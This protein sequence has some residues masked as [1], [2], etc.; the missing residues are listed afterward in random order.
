MSTSRLFA[1]H[2][3]RFA[4]LV[5]VGLILFWV[6][7][8]SA[9]AQDSEFEIDY[10]SFT[11]SNGLR[12]IVHEDRKAPIVAVNMWYGV[13]SKDE[14]EGQT[15]FAHLFEHLMYNGS[16][17]YDGE[18][19]K[20]LEQVGATSV[21]GNTWFDRTV[22][23]ESVPTPALELILWMES[24]RMGHLLGAVTQEKL[25][26]QRGVVQN[27]KR[28][29]DNQP[30]GM[31]SYRLLEG[32]FPTGHPY[33][34]TTIGSMD[35]L[36]AA[37]LDDIHTW[38]K[39]YYGSANAV[40]VL[41][42]DIDEETARPLV[43]K[44]FGH[45]PSGPPLQVW[46]SN[47]PDRVADTSEILYDDVAQARH[48]K[49]WAVPGR[50]EQERAHLDLAA[51]VLGDGKPS[52]LYKALVHEEQIATTASAYVSAHQLASFFIS[53]VDVK[54]GVSPDTVSARRD[55]IIQDFLR[56]GPT[57]KEL[58]RVKANM[59]A[60]ILRGLES[61]SG[62]EGVAGILGQ[63][64]LYANDP[65]FLSTYMKWI[66]EASTDMVRDAARAWLSD[67]SHQVSVL[68]FP[69][70]SVLASAADRSKLPYPDTTPDLTFPEVQTAELSNGMTVH[71]AQRQ[72]TG[73]VNMA[74]SF[75]AGYAADQGRTLGRAS[76][77][78]AMMDEGAD[79]K[80]AFEI[81][82][83]LE[84]LG[85]QLQTYSTLD[86]SIVSFSG[87][88]EN[89]QPTLNLVSAIV[90][91]PDFDQAELDLFRERWI[92]G[93]DQEKS[94]PTQVALRLLPPMLYGDGHAYGV[95]FTGSGT[96]AS[97]QSLTRDDLV[98]FHGTWLQPTNA[99]L[100]IVGDIDMATL[101]PM[102]DQ[103]FGKWRSTKPVPIK[104]VSQVARSTGTRIVLIN[105]PGAPQ[106]VIIGGNLA[107]SSTAPNAIA[108]T[109]INDVLGGEFTARIN[110]NLREDK[111]W[112]YGAQSFFYAARGQRPFAVYAPVQTD[113]TAESISEMRRELTEILST[114]PPTTDELDSVVALSTK[115]LPGSYETGANV[116]SS[117]LS[118][119]RF[120]RSF[121]YPATLKAS[122]EQLTLPN[123]QTAASEVIA[124][125]DMTWIIIGDL[126]EIE[127]PIRALNFGTVEVRDLD[128]EP[129]R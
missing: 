91:S 15:G 36:N 92:A 3:F 69:E 39:T 53:S 119:V 122:Y 95:P 5:L 73:I 35:D 2:S 22:Y 32:L 70:T 111:G 65:N 105:K 7:T 108:I 81:A 9:S 87:L 54:S 56:Q 37:T 63:G 1:T 16:E 21:N 129:V 40:L 60:D 59:K 61:V 107:P 57:R 76:F 98:D 123:L 31:A 30:Y 113:K 101:K 8:L 48:S 24:D 100:V 116:M 20:P 83:S 75:D 125:R 103:S 19:F 124:P 67:G 78:L 55:A 88:R 115:S 26:E 106:S 102:L 6:S 58:E 117:M 33:R 104:A 29:G 94:Q 80:D 86:T 82:E 4:L 126:S 121:D 68:P 46:Q 38:F 23:F 18:F 127:E 96:E 120:G 13:G 25:D 14:P 128:G 12:V 11:L 52:R 110:M 45:I 44:Y 66:D 84:S 85:A 41:A 90:R 42:G 17:N 47:V 89:L 77:A 51:R 118:S 114:R 28:Q 62:D 109:A 99:D 79:G 64:A 93:I 43:E 27:E 34:H 50:T 97:I 72:G 74:L 71:L 49:W 112:A 10:E